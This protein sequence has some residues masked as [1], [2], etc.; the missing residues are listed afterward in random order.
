MTTNDF[1]GGFVVGAVTMKML[2]DDKR[3]PRRKKEK[4]HKGL[5]S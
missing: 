2:D 5:L 1:V 3:H 4:K